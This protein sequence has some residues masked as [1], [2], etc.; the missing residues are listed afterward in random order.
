MGAMAAVLVFLREVTPHL[1]GLIA[2]V[3]MFSG[4]LVAAFLTNSLQIYTTRLL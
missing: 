4:T 3:M 1:I 2:G